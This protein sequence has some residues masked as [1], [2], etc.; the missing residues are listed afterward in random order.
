MLNFINI[1]KIF[2]DEA[3]AAGAF[4][5][6]TG[7][8]DFKNQVNNSLAF[9]GVFRGALDAKATIINNEMKLAAASAIASCVEP[10]KDNILPY[11]LDKQVSSKVAEAVKKAAIETG[12]C[13]E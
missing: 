5:V 8:S 4:I 9:P 3:L 7:R 6:A 2:P 12:V 11:T 13:R 1:K 10:K